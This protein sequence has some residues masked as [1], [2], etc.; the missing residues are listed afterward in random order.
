MDSAVFTFETPN[1]GDDLQTLVASHLVPRQTGFIHRESIWR[2]Q[3]PGRV[4]VLMNYWFTS[5]RLLLPPHASVAPVYHGFSMGKPAMLARGWQKNLERSQPIGCRDTSTVE[6]L[7]SAGIDAYWSGCITMYLGRWYRRVP[8]PAEPR[9]YL[10]DIPDAA[11]GIIPDRLRTGAV[12]LSNYTPPTLRQDPIGRWAAIARI[13]DVLR[14]AS[15][16][17][18]KRLHTAL[19]CAGFGIPVV[20]I[21]EDK[22][23]DRR[24]FSGYESFLPIIFHKDG[25]PLNQIDWDGVATPVYPAEI[26]TA[27]ARLCERLGSAPPSREEDRRRSIAAPIRLDIPNPGLGTHPGRIEITVGRH[28]HT[29]LADL[30]TD[31]MISA[32]FDAFRDVASFACPIT[33]INPKAPRGIVVGPLHDF[34]RPLDDPASEAVPAGS[35]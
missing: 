31:G 17:V 2:R 24:R 35:P 14:G 28:R 4:R 27:F 18:T 20:L 30:W 7:R 16:V 23:N 5:G 26:D 6:L 29:L 15:L 32:R 19:P 25:K 13:N 34:A 9:V 22:D 8:R 3:L 10:V 21:V 12:R 11:L 1:L 33:V